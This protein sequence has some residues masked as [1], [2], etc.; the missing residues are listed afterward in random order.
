M[1]DYRRILHGLETDELRDYAADADPDRSD[2]EV[3]AMTR[4]EL[5]R[6]LEADD[7][8]MFAELWENAHEE[9]GETM[10]PDETDEE[11]Y[12]HEAP[13]KDLEGD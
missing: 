2:A 7:C 9:Y 8:A 1:K 6:V 11:F 5:I 3:A 10:H 13:D 4:E 12:E